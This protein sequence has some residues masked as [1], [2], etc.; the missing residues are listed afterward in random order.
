MGGTF[1]VAIIHS[2][3]G[4]RQGTTLLGFSK[5]SSRMLVSGGL[6]AANEMT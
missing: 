1:S 2:F 4:R 6:V 3:S 5:R